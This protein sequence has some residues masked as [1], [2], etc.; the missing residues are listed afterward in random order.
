MRA[1]RC[2]LILA[3]WGTGFLWDD[4]VTLACQTM[5][6]KRFLNSKHDHFTSTSYELILDQYRGYRDAYQDGERMSGSS[7]STAN[8]AA[9]ILAI[10]VHCWNVVG[11]PPLLVLQ[12]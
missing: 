2:S 1:D 12:V 11:V 8:L 10:V 3:Y 9:V 6:R 4:A 5:H 7:D